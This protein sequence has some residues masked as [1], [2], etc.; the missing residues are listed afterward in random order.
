MVDLTTRLIEAQE[1]TNMKR[2][3][4]FKLSS[5]SV[6]EPTEEDKNLINALLYSGFTQLT[7]LGLD[8]NALWFGHSEMRSYL[9][10]SIR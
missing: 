6:G 8:N 1:D 3:T 5:K 4:L 10:D 2:L 7:Y 9:L